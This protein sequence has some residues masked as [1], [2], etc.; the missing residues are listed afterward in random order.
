MRHLKLFEGFDYGY[1]P[2]NHDDWLNLRF[3]DISE[4]TIMRLNELGLEID[5]LES[6]LFM[7]GLGWKSFL[8]GYGNSKGFGKPI[9]SISECD[10]GWYVF[11][12]G[13][14]KWK[15]D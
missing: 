1:E 3:Q 5:R 8:T 10:D 14:D 2:I 11:R 6:P 12:I 15:C 9:F 7:T 13:S 4:K